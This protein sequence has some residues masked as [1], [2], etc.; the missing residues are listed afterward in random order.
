MASRAEKPTYRA[1][2]HTQTDGL[3][4]NIMLLAPSIGQGRKM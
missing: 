4:E 2:T 1:S 3:R